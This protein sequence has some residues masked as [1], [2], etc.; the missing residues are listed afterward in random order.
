MGREGL[1]SGEMPSPHH[2]AVAVVAKI[3][4]SK[5]KKSVRKKGKKGG[6]VPM[7]M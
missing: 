1:W 5:G 6:A 4:R 2:S 3:K 7:I